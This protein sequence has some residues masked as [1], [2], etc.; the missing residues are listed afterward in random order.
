MGGTKKGKTMRLPV[1]VLLVALAGVVCGWEDGHYMKV[2][3]DFR[4]GT[5]APEKDAITLALQTDL[6]RLESVKRHATTWNGPISL[7]VLIVT[8]GDVD[9]VKV[10]LDSIDE[11]VKRHV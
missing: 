6:D 10:K 9:R 1:V 4:V 5:Q 3:K 2:N 7:S 8:E 11:Q